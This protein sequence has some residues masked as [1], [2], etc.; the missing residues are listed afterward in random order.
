GCQ[1]PIG[2]NTK[3]EGE[4]LTLTGSVASLDGQK[5]VKDVVSGGVNDAEQIGTELAQ[6]LRKQGAQEILDE[7]LAEIDRS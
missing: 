3:I 5:L 6:K 7:I 1:V 4:Q 2:V